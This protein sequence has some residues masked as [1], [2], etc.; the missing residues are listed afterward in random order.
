VVLFPGRPCTIGP[1]VLESGNTT[2]SQEK[3]S[4]WPPGVFVY[5]VAS[6]QSA[7]SPDERRRNA[8]HKASSIIYVQLG[9]ENGGI[10]V[11]LGIAGVSCQAATELAAEKNTTLNLRLRGSGLNADLLGEVVWVGATHKEVG[12]CFRSPSADV[13]QDIADWIEQQTHGR[14]TAALE[15]R[16]RAKPMAAM[17]GI[18]AQREKFATHS[19]SVALAMSRAASADRPSSKDTDGKESCLPAFS[20]PATAIFGTKPPPEI[21]FPIQHCNVI[22]DDLDDRSQSRKA[23]SFTSPEQRQI[24]QPLH[25]PTHVLPSPIELPDQSPAYSWSSMVLSKAA[26]PPV[27]DELPLASA[28]DQ[29]ESEFCKT[30]EINPTPRDR[31][32]RSRVRLLEPTS[33]ERWIPSVFLG[34][35][36]GGKRQ[37]RWLLAGTTGACL[38]F[39]ALIFT[40]AVAHIDSTLS[41]SAGSGSL[42]RSTVPP[43]ASI[44][45][46]DSPQAGPVQA[47]PA[48]PTVRPRSHRLPTSPFADLAASVLGYEPDK[49][50][51]PSEI[52]KDLVGMQVWTSKG[53]GYYY[54]TDSPYYKSVQPGNFMTQ[55]DAL[56]SGY[57]PKLGDFCD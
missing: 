51:V 29:G 24:A 23:D 47:P 34:A 41:R 54:C 42:Q 44:V 14:E 36:R 40:L 20:D 8:R 45:S 39:V 12:I 31:A 53:S 3:S 10:V 9:S 30:D 2:R 49:T 7:S 1:A 16:S 18:S 15:E 11:N 19:L 57:Q 17:P 27:H 32:P 6:A 55:G 56:Q 22:A 13:Q 33:A 37:Q 46:G 35:W 28:E 48:R 50:Y 21:P 43:A 52:D 26:M 38:G 25:S 5:P 4:P